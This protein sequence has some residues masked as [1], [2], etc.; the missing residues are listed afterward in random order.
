VGANQT[1]PQANMCAPFWKMRTPP[2]RTCPHFPSSFVNDH[3]RSTKSIPLP[4]APPHL[5][6]CPSVTEQS[7]TPMKPPS[8]ARIRPM[9]T[10]I[11]QV[12]KTSVAEFV[13]QN[14]RQGS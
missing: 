6:R 7:T 4:Q 13:K 9:G 14:P 10:Q 8:A 2:T 3:H 11:N 1:A 5:F 12:L